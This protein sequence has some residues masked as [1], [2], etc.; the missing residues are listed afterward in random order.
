LRRD[1]QQLVARDVEVV[2]VGPEDEATFANYWLQ[3]AL[4]YVGLPDPKGRVLSLYGQ[5]VNWL[6]LGRM[7]AQVLIDKAGV[8]RYA[9]YG[10]SMRDIP[11]VEEV[12]AQVDALS[13][14]LDSEEYPLDAAC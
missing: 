11:A 5:E 4:P 14:A 6:R 9:H 10:R 12:L 2:V 7:P 3:E 8:V 13:P 1:Y